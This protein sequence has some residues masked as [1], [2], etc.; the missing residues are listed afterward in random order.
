LLFYFFYLLTL[1]HKHNI[2]T[3]SVKIKLILHSLLNRPEIEKLENVLL[4]LPAYSIRISGVLSLSI[5]PYSWAT[6]SW[7]I[8][9]KIFTSYK[10]TASLLNI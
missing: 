6:F 10:K 5:N 7:L 1:R 2:Y 3:T 9:L 4:F 8:S